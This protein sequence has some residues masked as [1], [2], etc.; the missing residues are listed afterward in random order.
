MVVVSLR[1]RRFLFKAGYR[2]SKAVCTFEFFISARWVWFYRC[3]GSCWL[4]GWYYCLT[5]ELEIEFSR[6]FCCPRAALFGVEYRLAVR[7]LPGGRLGASALRKDWLEL[8]FFQSCK[9]RVPWFILFPHSIW[10]CMGL[11]NDI[12]IHLQMVILSNN[13]ELRLAKSGF[14]R[15]LSLWYLCY[16]PVIDPK[17]MLALPASGAAWSPVASISFHFCRFAPFIQRLCSLDP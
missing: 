13:F 16:S 9:L 11:S 2:F 6:W 10:Q 15:F 1:S 5:S 17:P 3:A 14:H 8:N 7:L 12:N 4:L